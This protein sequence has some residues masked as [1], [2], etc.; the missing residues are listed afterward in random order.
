MTN[1]VKLKPIVH[2]KGTVLWCGP[3]VLAAISGQKTS[4]V[5]QVLEGVRGCTGIKGVREGE[6]RS[7][8]LTL[9]YKLTPLAYAD[10]LTAATPSSPQTYPTLAQWTRKNRALLAQHTVIITVT[11]HY[12]VVSGNTFVDNHTKEP[13]RLKKAPHRRCR[14][15]RVCIVEATGEPVALPPAPEPKP[16]D[17][18]RYI[19]LRAQHLARKIGAQIEPH[20]PGEYWVYPPPAL[21]SEALDRHSDYHLGHDWGDVL[22]RVENYAD[23]LA[24]LEA[25]V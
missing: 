13:V 14:V 16:R 18:H 7:A 22:R 8:A 15:R 3:A 24:K 19:R 10:I 20:A 21:S 11:G 9:G 5:H 6:L 23:D 12:V 2:D 1:K 25:A 17:P 4:V